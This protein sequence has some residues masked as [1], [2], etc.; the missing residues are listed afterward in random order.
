MVGE[1]GLQPLPALPPPAMAA[2][3]SCRPDVLRPPPSCEDR[4]D[5]W[6][7]WW[8]CDWRGGRPMGPPMPEPVA[9]RPAA[10]PC[11]AAARGDRLT[12]DAVSEV[13]SRS[14]GGVRP[15]TLAAPSALLRELG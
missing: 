14:S 3:T 9:E 6:G 13:E 4:A 15:Q 1:P 11:P 5:D 12:S 8:G 10:L 7:Y 2:Q